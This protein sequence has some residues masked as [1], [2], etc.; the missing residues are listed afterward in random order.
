MYI[1]LHIHSI[2]SDSSRSPENIVRLAKERNVS[3]LSIC[4]HSSIAAYPRL[5][6]ACEKAGISQTLG[7]EV[8]ATLHG[9]DYDVLA[10]NFDIR[11]QAVL[12]FIRDQKER[13][14]REC[15]SMI[16]RMSKEYPALSV[17]DY[18]V[19]DRPTEKGGWKYIYYAV[20]RGIFETY[21]Q[22]G[23]HIFSNYYVV[24]PAET[25]PVEDLCRIVRDA[26]GVT[27]LAHPGYIYRRNPETFREFLQNMHERG[28]GG[29]ECFYPSHNKEITGSC[30]DY[31]RKN[32]LCITSG[33]DCHGDYDKSEGFTIGSLKITRDM[34]NLKGI[35]N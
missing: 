17:E 23:N 26:G 34:L 12:Q 20:D 15:E 1:D 19:Y 21:E 18:R 35:I 3:F 16:A 30:L 6:S 22:A 7:V 9:E 25:Y 5:I 32:N 10:Y 33:S 24:D 2:F 11:N 29:I 28:I 8:G 31:C 14:D 4:D 27:V 13:S